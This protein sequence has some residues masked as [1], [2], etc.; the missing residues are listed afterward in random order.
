MIARRASALAPS[1]AWTLAYWAV[2]IVGFVAV[3]A[4]DLPGK[5]SWD[6]TMQLY[7]GRTNHQVTFNPWIM[8]WILGLT[9][10]VVR[11][12][13]LFMALNAAI[14]FGSLAA[15]PAL[16]GFKL[17]PLAPLALA[18]VLATPQVVNY[19]GLVWKDVFFANL[20]VAAFVTL[21]FAVSV[22]RPGLRWAAYAK[23][24]VLLALA[25]LVRQNGAVAGLMAA[26]AVGAAETCRLGWKRGVLAGALGFAAAMVIAV[27][28][29]AAIKPGSSELKPHATGLSLLR[30]Y[31]I[32][33]A[34]ARDPK[35]DLSPMPPASQAVVRA[36]GPRLYTAERVDTLD[37]SDTLN[38]AFASTSRHD[39]SATWR[40]IVLH[41]PGL[42]LRHRLAV[43]G[44]VFLTPKLQQ[45]VPVE[46]GIDGPEPYLGRLGLKVG[47]THKDVLLSAYAA[48]FYNTPVF[49]HLA[50]AVLA[51]V[52][53][54]ALALRRRPADLAMMG[55][56]LSG[57]GFAASFLPISIACDYR[58]LYLLDLAS[59]AALVYWAI[60]PPALRLVPLRS[61]V[62]A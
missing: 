34:V 30:R 37:Y 8:S 58:Y 31:D 51:L 49:S 25:A 62:R 48:R 56:L 2:L 40:N 59:L 43:F 20:T 52:L 11:G 46:V 50:Y 4:I 53:L 44:Q 61:P 38:A 39:L 36:E 6:T 7:E 32:V 57:L 27:I 19:Q 55:L 33:G 24:V 28:L 17:P 47:S 54:A 22:R 29:G 12:V 9:D 21:A 1:L 42:Y 5:I 23:A 15:L 13:G 60:D 41:R 14:L 16:R 35:V 26:L 10:R 45:C 3:L 18:A